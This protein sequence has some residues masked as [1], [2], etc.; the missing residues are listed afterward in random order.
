MASTV[1]IANRALTKLGAA[2]ITSML[3]D[4]KSARVMNSMFD[5]VRDAELAAEPWSFASTRV[6]LPASSTAPAFGW[7]RSFPL[8]SDFLRLIEVGQDYVFYDTEDGPLFQVEGGAILTDQASPLQIRY[9]KRVTNS[10]LFP[11]LF[12]E[13]MACRLAA[14][15]CE[16]LTQNGS[17]REQA[18]A[19]RKQAV[20]DA[21]RANAIEQ[22][23]RRPPASSWVRAMLGW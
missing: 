1:Q 7:A 20:R 12:I 13:A 14:E 11:A 6:E 9:I 21:K 17:K 3:D 16:S 2:S 22:P 8:P 19:E 5:I 23:P 10:G 4:T 15:A 18:W